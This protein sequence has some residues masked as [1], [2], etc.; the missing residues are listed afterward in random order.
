MSEK[1][2]FL[3]IKFKRWVGQH[4][5]L[6][7]LGSAIVIVFGILCVVIGFYLAGADILAWFSSRWAFLVYAAVVAWLFLV[8]AIWY[9]GRMSK[10]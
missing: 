10:K 6:M 1:T 3:K 4:G 8:A 7:F 2:E 9:W 5:G